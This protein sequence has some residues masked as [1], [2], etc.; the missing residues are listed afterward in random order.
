MPPCCAIFDPVKDPAA[1]ERFG[2]SVF[3]S[4]DEIPLL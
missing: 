1:I 4:T 2:Q 3:A